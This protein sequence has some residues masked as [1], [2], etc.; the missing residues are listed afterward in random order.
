MFEVNFESIVCKELSYR[1][2]N[3]WFSTSCSRLRV[4]TT[5]SWWRCTRQEIYLL[6]RCNILTGWIVDIL[7]S[8]CHWFSLSGRQEHLD[9]DRVNVERHGDPVRQHQGREDRC[10]RWI[11][12]SAGE[13]SRRICFPIYNNTSRLFYGI[14]FS[15]TKE[16]WSCSTTTQRQI[17]C[18]SARG[19][20]AILLSFQLRS[21]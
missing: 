6:C 3:K 10:K 18:W 14:V 8:C 5:S 1:I 7:A 11:Q 17:V 19:R 21:I 13:R 9:E 15:M 20:F 4:I 2:N 12:R 16:T